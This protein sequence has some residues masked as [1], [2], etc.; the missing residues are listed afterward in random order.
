M[1]QRILS[2]LTLL[3]TAVLT[4]SAQ[5][6]TVKSFGVA[7]G[8]LAAS[9]Y[10]RNDR[11]GEPCGLIKVQLPLE[12]AYFEGNVMG[13]TQFIR[14]EYWVYMSR[15]SYRL[16]ILHPQFHRLDLNLRELMPA[17]EDG[18]RGVEP[19]VTYNLIIDVPQAI[20]VGSN[21][22][23]SFEVGD[24]TFYMV[25]VDGGTFTMGAVKDQDNDAYGRETTTHQVTLGTY[26]IGQTEVTQALWKAVMGKNPSSIKGDSLPVMKV[27]WDDCQTFIR[28]LNNLTGR[29]FRLPTEAEWEYAA[30]GG[31]KS[32]GYKYSGSN[33]PDDVAWHKVNSDGKPHAVMTLKP[34]ELDIYDMSGNVWEW[35]NDWYGRYRSSAK[36]SPQGPSR[37]STRVDRGGA[38]DYGDGECRVTYRGNR[39]PAY[40]RNN[41]GLR[42]AL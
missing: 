23:E 5:D 11:N 3:L 12:G 29:I 18:F 7:Q 31:S 22:M 25:K 26:Y 37:G 4:V 19:K 36:E 15:T 9:V 13:D 21:A 10:P 17:A 6:L 32:Q 20:P 39:S 38:W 8:D 1:S 42:L 34:N 14:G 24:Q 41:L 27:S 16:S 35:C 28:R 30:R 40:R 33:T 2:L